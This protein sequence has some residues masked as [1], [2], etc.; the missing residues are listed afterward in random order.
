MMTSR[1]GLR[2]VLPTASGLL[3]AAALAAQP[4]VPAP[5]T[6]EVPLPSIGGWNATL[7]HESDAGIWTVEA[8]KAF[9]LYGCPEV[10][11][12]DDKGRCTVL[13][14]YSGK[15]TPFPTVE[16]REWLG[17]LASADLDPR[18][19]GAEIYTGG[20][21][22]NLYQIQCHAGGGADTRVIARFPGIEIHTL[23]A[24]DLLPSRPGT[25]MLCF[26]MGGEVFDIRPGNGG[27]DFSSEL[28]LRLPGRVRQALLLPAASGEAPR[29][30]TASRG[31]EVAL[32]TWTAGGLA[33]RPVLRE[34]MGFGRLAR[35]PA[36]DGEVPVL[37]ATRDDG[38]VV[39][40]EEPGDGPWRSE[41]IYAGPQGPRGIAA[42]RFHEDPAQETVAVFGYGGKVQ[43]LARGPDGRWDVENIFAD[44]DK[45]HWLA[46]AELDGRNA[47]D[48]LIGSGYGKRIF[49]L[50]RPP[51]YGRK[52]VATEPAEPK[53]A[54]A[55]D[56][57][58][59]AGE[60]D[61]PRP[62]RLP[63]P[64]DRRRP[65]GCR[66]SPAAAGSRPGRSCT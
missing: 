5:L 32:L 62:F 65:K 39:R 42:G 25:E 46:T 51:G 16:D 15:W 6:D 7:V 31:G 2:T 12:L 44:R 57:V 13:M 50:S 66:R 14:S 56:P 22:G 23:I 17:G 45:G 34:P 33:N 54:K 59:S 18:L 11:G 35:K 1:A 43:L 41:V 8:L 21:R 52:G 38:V 10:V 20:K 64:P 60:G 30:A 47:T 24:G 28:L 27:A 19:P 9:P 63:W 29:I 61:G 49:L 26:A 48:E 4:Q 40:L 53:S 58:R 37:Y 36:R 3:L 55:G